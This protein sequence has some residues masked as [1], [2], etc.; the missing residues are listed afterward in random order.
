MRHPGEGYFAGD[1]PTDAVVPQEVG[2]ILRTT[3]EALALEVQRSV[4]FYLATSSGLKLSRVVL[5]GGSARVTGLKESLES[6]L[7]VPVDLADPFKAL[8]FK[9]GDFDAD[10]LKDLAPLSA[11][12]TGLATRRLGDKPA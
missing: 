7:N 4:D 5:S 6:A 9:P 2:A 8:Q 12:V 11:V 1:A 10:M 3:S